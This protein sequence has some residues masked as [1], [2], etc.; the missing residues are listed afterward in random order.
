MFAQTPLSGSGAD[1]FLH[2]Q[3]SGLLS[4]RLRLPQ[5]QA[6][7]G[8]CR[9]CR[10][11]SCWSCKAARTVLGQALYIALMVAS[12]LLLLQRLTCWQVASPA[13]G[14]GSPS[15]AAGAADCA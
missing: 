1:G 6:L 8:R 4:I 7:A 9:C 11:E 10:K 15:L 13:G 3:L 12:T 5:V 2:L 14:A